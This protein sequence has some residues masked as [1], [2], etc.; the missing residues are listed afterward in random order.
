[1]TT[2]ARLRHALAA[3]RQA[4]TLLRDAANLGTLDD[5]TRNGLLDQANHLDSEVERTGSLR[6]FA[7]QHM[8]AV[9]AEKLKRA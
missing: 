6:Y 7:N 4:A 3:L 9:R 2:D 1:M 8:A 5:Y